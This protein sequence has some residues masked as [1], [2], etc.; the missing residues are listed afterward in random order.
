[1]LFILRLTN[2]DCV[3][4]MAADEQGAR[5]AATK[6][7]AN[8]RTQVASVRPF[9]R[10]AVQFSPTEDGSLEVT[11]WDDATL[12]DILKSE[13]PLLNEAFRRANAEPFA[14]ATDPEE[15]ILSHLRAAHQRNTEII[16]QGLQLERERFS[17]ETVPV[18][19]STKSKTSPA[20][21]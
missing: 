12:D 5:A 10:L 6:L 15:P 16:R 9:G 17:K 7:S 21:T 19:R 3:I 4:T 14:R 1:M 8:D 13:Y 18:K 20:H 11:R 2:G